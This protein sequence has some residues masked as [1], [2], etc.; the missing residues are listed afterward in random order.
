MGLDGQGVAGHLQRVCCR[1]GVELHRAAVGGGVPQAHADGGGFASAIGADH[2]QAFARG[3][4]K[5][6]IVDHRGVAVAFAQVACL[7]QGLGW[8]R[9][10]FVHGK[11]F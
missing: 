8:G 10:G 1:A 9:E 5:R 6:Y 2:A 7:E 11:R 4:G 3:N